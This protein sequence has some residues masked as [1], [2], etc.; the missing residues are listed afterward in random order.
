MPF[1]IPASSSG[2]VGIRGFG[3]EESVVLDSVALGVLGSVEA[4]VSELFGFGEWVEAS[5]SV[6]TELQAPKT[7]TS[8]KATINSI[9]IFFISF[10]LKTYFRQN[11][12]LRQSK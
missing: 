7:P 4:V 11:P 3:S 8:K 12:K 10:L 1:K 2:S 9:A 6:G 5:V